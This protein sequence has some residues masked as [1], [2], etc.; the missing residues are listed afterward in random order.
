MS[1]VE[2]TLGEV[3]L[4][5]RNGSSQRI[6]IIIYQNLSFFHLS[7]YNSSQNSKEARMS[8]PQSKKSASWAS[9]YTDAPFPL[10]RIIPKLWNPL[11]GDIPNP[12]MIA[13][14]VVRLTGHSGRSAAFRKKKKDG[15]GQR[16]NCSVLAL[17]LI[18]NPYNSLLFRR[19]SSRSFFRSSP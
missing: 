2:L 5:L 3:A 1:T 13:N 14:S 6:G 4:L 16:R 15:A 19:A 17:P 10:F 7:E 12:R 8:I 18:H 11:V 9:V